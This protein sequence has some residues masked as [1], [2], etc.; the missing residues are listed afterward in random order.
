MIKGY[1]YQAA[2]ADETNDFKAAHDHR[3]SFPG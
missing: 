1:P 3:L 2:K